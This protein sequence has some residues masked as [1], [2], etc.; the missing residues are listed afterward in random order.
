[1]RLLTEKLLPGQQLLGS[2][3]ESLLSPGTAWRAFWRQRTPRLNV[4][5]GA[6][7]E[8]EGQGGRDRERDLPREL[9]TEP[10][11]HSRG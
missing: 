6:Q 4:V 8:S 2:G 5:P 10:C 11:G 3:S 7:N 9:N 1:M